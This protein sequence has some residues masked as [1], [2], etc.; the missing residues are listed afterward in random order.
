[1]EN[2]KV[3]DIIEDIQ[4]AQ[5]EAGGRF[6]RQ[7]EIRKMTVEELLNLLIPNN[8]SFIIKFKK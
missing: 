5:V 6:L 1:M 2:K 7:F 8:V 4:A 3:D